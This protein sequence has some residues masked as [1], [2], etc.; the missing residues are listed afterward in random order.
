MDKEKFT[1]WLKAAAVR[2]VR[3]FAQSMGAYIGTNAIVLS[4][5]N[6]SMALSAGALGAVLSLIMSLGGLPE[7]KNE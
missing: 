2:A 5:V 4:E 7:V 6:W 1:K 3:T